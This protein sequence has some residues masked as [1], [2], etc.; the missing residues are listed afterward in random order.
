MPRI[1]VSITPEF[2]E[3]VARYQQERG[4]PSLSAALVELAQMAATEVYGDQSPPARKQWGGDRKS[5]R[6]EQAE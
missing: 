1:N 5:K 6:D 4:L 3:I 2:Q